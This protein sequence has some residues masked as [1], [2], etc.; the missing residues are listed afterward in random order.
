MSVT[1][2][3]LGETTWL[4]TCLFCNFLVEIMIYPGHDVI[5]QTVDE[6]EDLHTEDLNSMDEFVATPFMC[7]SHH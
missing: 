2:W 7:V 1:K 6:M 3:F 5:I 4:L